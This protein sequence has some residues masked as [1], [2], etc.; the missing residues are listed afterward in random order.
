MLRE[1]TVHYKPTFNPTNVRTKKKSKDS[2]KTIARFCARH[3]LHLLSD[4]IYANTVFVNPVA[5][6]A[7]VFTSLLAMDL[8][9]I[10][11]SN[12]VHVMY[13]ASKDFCANGMRLGVLHS[14][15][16]ELREAVSSIK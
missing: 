6:E 12:L 2:I 4:E 14:R 10:I 16:E 11:D 13:G 15:S 9:D 3:D 5:P 8:D 1:L 7:T